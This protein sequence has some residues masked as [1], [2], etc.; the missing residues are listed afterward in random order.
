MNLTDL[1][2][3][4]T[5]VFSILSQY[6]DVMGKQLIC[7]N[8]YL[9]VLLFSCPLLAWAG[10]LLCLALSAVVRAQLCGHWEACGN[11]ALIY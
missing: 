7:E 4:L 5:F 11:A 2:L 10:F 8:N 1:S 3:N 9:Y 6:F